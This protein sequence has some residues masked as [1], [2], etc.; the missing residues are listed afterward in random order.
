MSEH[1]FLVAVHL[2][3]NTEVTRA[4][5]ESKVMDLL[6]RGMREAGEDGDVSW[7]VAEDDRTDGSDN[8]SAVFVKRH[9]QQRAFGVLVSHG[10][11]GHWNNP[12]AQ[13]Q[14]NEP[15]RVMASVPN[16]ERW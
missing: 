5:A 15:K 3:D 6:A 14:I 16:E 9:E 1:V 12:R 13:R 4:D 2:H 7:W 10:L 8:D 11:T